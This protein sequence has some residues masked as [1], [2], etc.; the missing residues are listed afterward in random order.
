MASDSK[1]PVVCSMQKIAV[2]GVNFHG[3]PT[4]MNYRIAKKLYN[5][6]KVIFVSIARNKSVQTSKTHEMIDGKNKLLGFILLTE[7]IFEL[8]VKRV[9][10]FHFFITGE[11]VTN[12]FLYS[13]IK[14]FGGKVIC[15]VS[16]ESQKSTPHSNYAIFYSKIEF[17]KYSLKEKNGFYLPPT[18]FLPKGKETKREKTCLF[19]SVPFNQTQLRDHGIFKLIEEFGNKNLGFKLK[20]LNRSKGAEKALAKKIS[21]TKNPKNVILLN[22]SLSEKA[23]AKEYAKA[24]ILFIPFISGNFPR[25]PLSAIEALSFG[26]PLITTKNDIS[27]I[28]SQHRAGIEIKNFEEINPAIKVINANYKIFSKNAKKLFQKQFSNKFFNQSKKAFLKRVLFE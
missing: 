28:V 20:I 25:S 7:K 27:K 15:T 12:T 22:R 4:E 5:G 8:I 24:K 23:L 1:H 3:T 17:N 21:L 10:V 26:T 16:S 9:K 19:A 11:T 14:F 18:S 6:K 2:I 13:I